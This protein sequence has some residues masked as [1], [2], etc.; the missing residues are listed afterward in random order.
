[1]GGCK[2]EEE[3]CCLTSLYRQTCD[4]SEC[5]CPDSEC[6]CPDGFLVFQL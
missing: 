2:V 3:E 1:M 4:V 5:R 6:R